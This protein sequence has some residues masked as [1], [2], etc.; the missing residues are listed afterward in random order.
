[1][2]ETTFRQ[3]LK[4]AGKQPH[5]IEELVHQAH[6]FEAYL[7]QRGHALDTASPQDIHDYVSTL[8]D[9][10]AKNCLR[11]VAL[12]FRSIGNQELARLATGLREQ[13]IATT[14]QAIR[15]RE[16]RGIAPDDLSRLDEAG[17]VTAEHMLA[18]GKTPQ[19][20]RELAARTGVSPQLILEL[21][22]LSDLSRIFGVK[23]TRA[24]L[25]YDAGLDTPYKLAQW[26]PEALRQMLIDFVQRTGFDGIAPL[27][28]EVAFTIAAARELPQAVEY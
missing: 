24:R 20:R 8:N 16:F 28:K 18:A 17:I 14:R 22:K 23:A 25:Y 27:P 21:V 4:K 6:L 12:Y 11:G 7:N 15:L 3:S 1:M 19:L 26:Q 2:D 9:R 13:R 5:V 10:E